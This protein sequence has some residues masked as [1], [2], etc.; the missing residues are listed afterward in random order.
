MELVEFDPKVPHT[1]TFEGEAASLMAGDTILLK[2][3]SRGEKKRGDD[4]GLLFVR[5][6]AFIHVDD[7]LGIRFDRT[8]DFEWLAGVIALTHGYDPVRH[9]ANPQAFQLVKKAAESDESESA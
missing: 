7:R 4:C 5:K 8:K 9:A 6:N 1:F 3:V 2:E